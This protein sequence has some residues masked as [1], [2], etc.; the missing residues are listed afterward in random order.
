MARELTKIEK[1]L[2]DI[3][4]DELGFF[5]FLPDDLKQQ[6]A[7]GISL[8]TYMIGL[9]QYIIAEQDQSKIDK[10]NEILDAEFKD[11]MAPEAFTA[12]QDKI[13]LEFPEII[14]YFEIAD[15]EKKQKMVEMAVDTI[16]WPATDKDESGYVGSI[17]DEL[18]A[19][20]K[21]DDEEKFMVSFDRL[22]TH[23]K[24]YI[25]SFDKSNNLNSL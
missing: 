1:L 22:K 13:I 3:S 18:K 12:L 10:M 7:T 21:A 11:D 16:E 2:S 6:S 17:K 8:D 5:D 9:E 23:Y 15:V 4:Y 19:A 20:I 24:Q 14:D 25:K